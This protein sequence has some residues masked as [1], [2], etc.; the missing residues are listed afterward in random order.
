MCLLQK[1]KKKKPFS[2]IPVSVIY[3]WK[4]LGRVKVYVKFSVGY[5]AGGGGGW[6][7]LLLGQ[8]GDELWGVEL[9]HV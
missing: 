7:T 1:K 8:F 9:L 5:A 3:M 2:A 6:K 4:L